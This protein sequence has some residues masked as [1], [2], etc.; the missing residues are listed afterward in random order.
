MEL[1]GASLVFQAEE[2]AGAAW[3]PLPPRPAPQLIVYPP[4][5]LTTHNVSVSVAVHK[6]CKQALVKRRFL[7]THGFSISIAVQK[8]MY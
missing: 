3:V 5:F 6:S 1:L 7:A 4:R 2:E 8:N